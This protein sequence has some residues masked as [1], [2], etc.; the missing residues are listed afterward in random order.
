[1]T[2]NQD[3]LD[4]PKGEMIR[5]LERGRTRTGLTDTGTRTIAEGSSKI[6]EHWMPGWSDDDAIPFL[7]GGVAKLMCVIPGAGEFSIDLLGP[8]SFLCRPS[9]A[10]GP[11]IDASVGFRTHDGP[12]RWSSS[13]ARSW[14]GR[15][16]DCRTGT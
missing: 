8:G 15:W 3:Y 6:R 2:M 13:R 14:R 4:G 11:W 16:W 9:V 10:L 7:I 12:L 1:M 5:L